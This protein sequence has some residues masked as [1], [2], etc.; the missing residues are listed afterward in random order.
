[1]QPVLSDIKGD[2]RYRVGIGSAPMKVSSLPFAA[3]FRKSVEQNKQ[4]S[5]LILELVQ[6]MV[7]RKISIRSI[8]GPIGIGRAAG[9]AASKKG[10]DSAFG[11]DRRNQS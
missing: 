11:I 7:Q 2:Q 1:M 8:E 10:L 3:A 9:Q 6:K 4:G 5:L